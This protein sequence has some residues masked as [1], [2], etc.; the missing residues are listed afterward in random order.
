M[1][2]AIPTDEVPELWRGEPLLRLDSN[3]ARACLLEAALGYA[4]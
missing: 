4:H 3:H 1:Q 2:H